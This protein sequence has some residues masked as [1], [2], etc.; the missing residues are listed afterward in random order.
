MICQVLYDSFLLVLQISEKLKKMRLE[1]DSK[2]S[3][4]TGEDGEQP[5]GEFR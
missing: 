3:W 5:Y 2:I 1:S 4:R